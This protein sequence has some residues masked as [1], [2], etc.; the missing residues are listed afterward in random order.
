MVVEA[1][2]PFAANFQV[3]ALKYAS[4]AVVAGLIYKFLRG[5]FPDIVIKPILGYLFF[6]DRFVAFPRAQNSFAVIGN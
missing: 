2:H 3:F 6:K 5:L 4:I 1:F